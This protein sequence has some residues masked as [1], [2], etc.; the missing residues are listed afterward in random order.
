MAASLLSAVMT[1]R[2]KRKAA[3]GST[4]PPPLHALALA[5]IVLASA[6]SFAVAAQS[7]AY[8]IE[9]DAIPVPLTSSAGDPA[10]GRALL[11]AR[12]SA[13]CVLCH[14]VPDPAMRVAG[15]LGP[16]LDG[17]GARLTAAQ[18][19]LRVVDMR[20]VDP[21]TIMPSYYRIEGLTMVADAYR[22]KPILSAQEVED[23]VAYLATLR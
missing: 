10:R 1:V 11:V 8:K 17:V 3:P 5:A 13:N 21:R 20:R 23:V 7:M 15:D 9:A 12:D 14:A 18:L 4:Y 19:R 2:R 22:G 16:A 6:A